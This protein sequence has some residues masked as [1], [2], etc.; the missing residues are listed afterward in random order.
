MQDNILGQDL[1]NTDVFKDYASN[2]KKSRIAKSLQKEW[3]T[4]SVYYKEDLKEK[5]KK[6][7]SLFTLFL[8]SNDY[9][10]LEDAEYRKQFIAFAKDIECRK[11]N[12]FIQADNNIVAILQSPP[13]KV[14]NKSNKAEIIKFLGYDWSNRK[15]DE[16]IKYLTSH[17]QDVDSSDDDDDKDNE[18]VQ[19]INSIKY[20]ETPLY[21]PN[22]DNDASKFSY[23]LRKHITE[24]CNKFSFGLKGNSIINPFI[25]ESKGLLHY[26]RLT[27]MIRFDSTTFNLAIKTDIEKKSKEVRYKW[28]LKLFKDI[29]ST[30]E[31]G[32]RPI[33]G[34]GN[35]TSG[36]LSLGGEHID[37]CSG[38]LNLSEPKYVPVDFYEKADK[39]KLQKDDLLICKDGALTGK[40]AIVRDEL[41]GLKAMVNEHVFI[42]RCRNITLQNYLFV[43]LHSSIGQDLLRSNITGSAQGGLNRSNLSQIKIPIPS[44]SIQNRIV[45]EAALSLALLHS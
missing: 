13:D 28:P 5:T 31:T 14:D 3:F 6:Y 2:F 18:I 45:C 42:V 29:I 33:G 41:E 23:A 15:G 10:Q 11:L 43:F 39:G 32:S 16:G 35:I 38:Y 25:E 8:A 30:I 40:V 36:V 27:D 12:V 7:K 44:N 26:A 4:Q 22:D 20:I 1:E 19:A 21:N 34:V 24:C 17:F 9:K 37:N